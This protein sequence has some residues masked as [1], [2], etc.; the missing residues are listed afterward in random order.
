[1]SSDVRARKDIFFIERVNDG[2]NE[3]SQ[4]VESLEVYLSVDK[5]CGSTLA[6]IEDKYRRSSPVDRFPCPE[7]S[8]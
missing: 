5:A 8:E 1:M 6:D 3:A 7:I 2:L 4:K